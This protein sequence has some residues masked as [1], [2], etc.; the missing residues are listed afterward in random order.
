VSNESHI[1]PRAEGISL[2]ARLAKAEAEV[3]AIKRLVTI[4]EHQ[5]ELNKPVTDRIHDMLRANHEWAF[6]PAEI[7]E[8]VRAGEEAVR[9]ALQRLAGRGQ[10]DRVGHGAYRLN[11][12]EA[13]RLASLD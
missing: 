1:D 10:I 7:M 3:A 13:N 9:K 11:A 12:W 5:P 6:S 2:R 8:A 4:A